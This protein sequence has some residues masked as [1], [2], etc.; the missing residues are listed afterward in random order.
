MQDGRP[1]YTLDGQHLPNENTQMDLGVLIDSQLKFH[2]HNRNVTRMAGGVAQS[3]LKGAVCREPNFM[4]HIL[5]THIRPILEYASTVWNTGYLQDIRRLESIQ[6]LW[7]RQIKGLEDKDYGT[8]LRA[9]DLYSVKGRFLRA[10]LIKCWKIFNGSCLIEP[11]D[12][13]EMS[14]SSRTRG[15]RF[16]IKVNRCQVDARAR[17]FSERIVQDWN[18]LPDCAVSSGTLSGF[19]T[20][21]DTCLTEKLFDY[22][23]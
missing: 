21:M 1:T 9:L 4:V 14:V 15:H 17:F 13:W 10:D 3:F 6:R 18:S 11:T 22:L 12:L 16:K 23:H 2:D 5:K 8:R 20:A 7:T 19:K